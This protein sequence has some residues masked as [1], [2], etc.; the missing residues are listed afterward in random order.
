LGNEDSTTTR[1]IDVLSTTG[2]ISV[3]PQVIRPVW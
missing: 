3:V 2:P 1:P